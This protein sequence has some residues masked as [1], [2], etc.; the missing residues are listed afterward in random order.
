MKLRCLLRPSITPTCGGR[1]CMTG[2]HM[3]EESGKQLQRMIQD[4][5]A[6]FERAEHL[7]RERDASHGMAAPAAKEDVPTS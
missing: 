6:V 5:K 7:L 3:Q 4:G 2:L 1:T